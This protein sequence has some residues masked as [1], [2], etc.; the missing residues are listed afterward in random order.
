[1]P[2][3]FGLA[4]L[5]ALII[6]MATGDRSPHEIDNPAHGVYAVMANETI[7][8]EFDQGKP[9]TWVE[10]HVEVPSSEDIEHEYHL[11]GR[12]TVNMWLQAYN[13]STRDWMDVSDVATKSCRQAKHNARLCVFGGYKLDDRG[14]DRLRFALQLAQHLEHGA[15]LPTH[16]DVLQMGPIGE[17]KVCAKGGV[18]VSRNRVPKSL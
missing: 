9:Y 10:A 6:M 17:A 1:M 18:G 13:E 11:A 3:T 14:G 15:Y 8:V 2:W 7:G 5:A 4:T 16:V 12:N